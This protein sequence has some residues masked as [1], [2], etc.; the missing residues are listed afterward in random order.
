MKKITTVLL[1]AA[2]ALVVQAQVYSP[3]PSATLLMQTDGLL[4]QVSAGGSAQFATCRGIGY[5]KYGF[6]SQFGVLGQ[7]SSS[8]TQ[9]NRIKYT[10]PSISAGAQIQFGLHGFAIARTN[11]L[12]VYVSIYTYN[13]SAAV[14]NVPLGTAVVRNIP[15][16]FA[17]LVKEPSD[18]LFFSDAKEQALTT[19]ALTSGSEYVLVIAPSATSGSASSANCV[20]LLTNNVDAPG[21]SISGLQ[22]GDRNIFKNEY[23]RFTNTADQSG[24]F[25][26]FNSD[27]RMLAFRMYGVAFKETT[28]TGKGTSSGTKQ[29]PGQGKS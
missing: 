29:D 9:F 28:I 2:A 19:A 23:A 18:R 16:R 1:C 12:S 10:G 25:T 7:L 6:A 24:T 14:G 8:R 15:V 22:A 5:D 27:S 17:E 13:G 11:N 21:T 4:S 3:A 20:V 26:T